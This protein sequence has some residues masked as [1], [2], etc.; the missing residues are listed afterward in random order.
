MDD[1]LKSLGTST[2]ITD[3]ETDVIGGRGPWASGVYPV[4]IEMAYLDEGKSGAVSIN[5]TF[6]NSDAKKVKMTEYITSGTAK[7]RRNYYEKGGKKFY[8]PGFNKLNN[9][10]LLAA[11]KD[12][13]ELEIQ[14]KLIKV[15]DFN[16]R[17]EEP[18]KKQVVMGLL[19]KEV[20]LGILH[21]I[22]DKRAKDT[23][24]KYVPTGE[25][26]ETNEIAKVFRMEDGK[27]ITEIRGQGDA[28]FIEKWSKEFTGLVIDRSTKVK[29]PDLNVTT[30]NK[31]NASMFET[32][33][34]GSPKPESLFATEEDD[35]PF[36]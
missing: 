33:P 31:P 25:T 11:G 8:L 30:G 24:G 4:T 29:G 19:G 3:N 26:R 35:V 6:V 10:C 7:G 32:P 14:K 20:K 36:Q 22:E 12:F 27:T 1:F 18:Q 16:S 17:K 15:Y 2:D 13:S 5:F 21:V 23:E 34:S 9:I 28:A